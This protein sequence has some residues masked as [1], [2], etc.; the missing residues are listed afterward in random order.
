MGFWDF[1]K[2][3]PSL[4]QKHESD[5]T[6][7]FPHLQWETTTLIGGEPE[8]W[9]LRCTQCGAIRA[10][11]FRCSET[12]QL[13]LSWNR[14]FPDVPID[15]PAGTYPQFEEPLVR[16]FYEKFP[17]AGEP[18]EEE[19]RLAQERV[20]AHMRQM[21]ALFESKRQENLAKPHCPT[22]GSTDVQKISL[23]K[24][25]V[26]TE[27]LGLASPTIG[28]TMECKKCGYKW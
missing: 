12:G 18:N 9:C 1:L 27:L 13:K 5:P 22:C 2:P 21:D 19:A 24:K 8:R 15:A 11:T 20:E 28:K 16:L 14:W 4:E 10:H 17:N 3:E 25:V 23:T 6:L 26:S 7:C